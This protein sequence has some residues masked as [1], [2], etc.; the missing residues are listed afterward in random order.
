MK[1]GFL[2]G[3]L[4]VL[5][6]P[7]SGAGATPEDSAAVIQTALDY[8]D[9]YYTADSTRMARAV[10]PDIAKRIV[11]PDSAGNDVVHQMTAEQLVEI[12]ARGSGSKTPQEDRQSDVVI[13]DFFHQTA[14]VRI[15]AT[16]WIDYLHIAKVN[17]EWK[18]IN[19]LWEYKPEYLERRKRP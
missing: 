15:T 4:V 19:V 9:G 13:L 1:L 3:A 18:I 10:H 2:M 16:Y 17:G 6:L 7:A 8:I 14:S 5:T 11:R 12:T